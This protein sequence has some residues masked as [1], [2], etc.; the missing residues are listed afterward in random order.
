MTPMTWMQKPLGLS[1]ESRGCFVRH[2]TSD[3]SRRNE[4]RVLDVSNSLTFSAGDYPAA[5]PSRVCGDGKPIPTLSDLTVATGV[6][7]GLTPSRWVARLQCLT[8]DTSQMH[9]RRSSSNLSFADKDEFLPRPP[10]H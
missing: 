1:D 6:V 5:N 10:S 2:S 9:E 7:I 3:Q 4:G 8:R